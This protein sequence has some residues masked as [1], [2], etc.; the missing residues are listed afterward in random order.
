MP[1]SKIIL[2]TFLS[3]LTLDVFSQLSLLVGTPALATNVFLGITVF[4]SL[5]LLLL[6]SKLKWKNKIPPKALLV[7]NLNLLWG[8]IT[9]IH[10]VDKAQ[11]YWDW[12]ILILG[13][14]PTVLLT[15]AIVLGVNF[16]TSSKV[17]QFLLTKLFPISF[18]FIPFTL[19]YTDELYARLVAPV[20]LLVLITPYLRKNLQLLV[21]VV[22]L[23]SMGIDF[24]Y[25][26]NSIRILIPLMVIVVFYYIPVVRTKMLNWIL[27]FSFCLP[28]FLL[29]LGVS[30][31]FNIFAD[32]KVSFEV[33]TVLQGEADSSD[34]GA[35]TRTFLY[36]E[37]FRSMMKRDSSFIFGEGGAAG[38][39]TDF[40]SDAVLNDRGRYGSEVGFLNMV[41]RSGA[42]GVL[43][44]A[45]MLFVP[46]YY[47]INQSNNRLCKMLAL[48]LAARWLLYFVEDMALVDMNYF[49][50]WLTIGLCLSNRFRAMSDQQ[51]KKFFILNRDQRL[52][53]PWGARRN[54][55]NSK[56]GNPIKNNVRN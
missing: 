21:I 54:I 41:M 12:K 30:G 26:A 43:L 3:L 47:A 6:S 48:F 39:E 8:V 9:I 35:D 50:L 28:L 19:A 31:E 14:L 1:Y 55:N 15:Y 29:Q 33:D 7:F 25:R 13:Y 2:V 27:I 37:V 24:S 38:Y 32:H 16:E 5:S 4:I 22:A 20:C 17:F 18:I 40:F 42:I 45:L 23:I 51:L 52:P 49:F 36:V 44:Y 11:D 46:A 10:G 34:V 56:D 53:M